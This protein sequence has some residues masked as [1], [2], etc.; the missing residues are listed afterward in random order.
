MKTITETV[1][2]IQTYAVLE[3][4][5]AELLETLLPLRAD[6]HVLFVEPW[7]EEALDGVPERTAEESYRAL[8][9]A[10]R[11]GD[12]VVAHGVVAMVVASRCKALGLRVL[13]VVPPERG[14]AT[15]AE[16]AR[17][18]PVAKQ[19]RLT[20]ELIRKTHEDLEREAPRHAREAHEATQQLVKQVEEMHDRATADLRLDAD[21]MLV[22]A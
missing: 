20:M 6:P 3:G 16:L 15:K 19:P 13:L 8:V 1:P 12:L 4:D 11:P 10:T 7:L 2:Q 5:V 9:V 18:W 17:A 22:D 21:G 14:E